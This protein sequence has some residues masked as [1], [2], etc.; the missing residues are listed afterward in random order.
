[1]NTERL[2]KSRFDAI[3][4]ILGAANCV[5]ILTEFANKALKEQPPDVA[6]AHTALGFI[7]RMNLHGEVDCA[8]GNKPTRFGNAARK[9]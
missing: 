9:C 4:A 8:L 2:A 1:V 3:G 7:S 5:Q 6:A